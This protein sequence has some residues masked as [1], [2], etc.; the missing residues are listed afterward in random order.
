M[1]KR[2][3]YT[4]L[5]A[6]FLLP[7][8]NWSCEKS[9]NSEGGTAT[10]VETE[11]PPKPLYNKT[12]TM[13]SLAWTSYINS[14]MEGT[15]AELQSHATNGVQKILT[16]PNVIPNIGQWSVEWGPITYTHDTTLGKHSFSD[17]T[18]MLL[19]GLDPGTSK[20]MYVVA[21]AGTNSSSLFDWQYED[22]AATQMV[23]WP[24]KPAGDGNN[25]GAFSHPTLENLSL[26][27]I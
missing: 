22:L 27:H 13:L 16:N 26:I 24:A 7:F 21:I 8:L 3:I 12:A 17:N 2:R 6:I 15:R 4:I 5:L 18:M 19:K 10:E 20:E 23:Q 1:V 25:S 11:A 14:G 9:G